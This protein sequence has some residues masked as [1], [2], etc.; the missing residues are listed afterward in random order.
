MTSFLLT[1]DLGTSSERA[2]L[3]DKDLNITGT[4]Q[5]A[6][7]QYYPQ[8]GWVEQ[9]PEEIWQTQLRLTRRLL[10]SKDL[11]AKDI[12][13]IGIT[14][15][16]ETVIVWDRRSGKALYPAIVWQDKR[17]SSRCEALRE[18][19]FSDRVREK[20]GL[21]IDPYFSA[22]KLQWILEKVPG[23]RERAEAGDLLF[24][25]VDSWIVWRLTGG[26]LH[27]TDVSNASRT[28]LFN[29]HDREWDRELLELFAIPEAML[30]EVRSSSEVYT[31]TLPEFFG[32]PIPV[33]GIAG[34]QQ[35]ALFGQ[36]CTEA[37]MAK[38]TYGTGCFMLMNTGS[39]AVRSRHGLLTT[40]AWERD[41]KLSY[42]LEGAVF[43][44]GASIQWL[45][46]NL[47]I[48][49]T[50]ADSAATAAKLRDNGGVYFVPA[51]SGLGAPHWDMNVR[52]TVSGLTQG[53]TAEHLIR[54]ALESIAYQ[55]KD[56]L[57]AM[58]RDS[59][60]RLK[61]LNA[62]GGATANDFL[63]QFQADILHCP[64]HR[65]AI[66]ESTALG[67]AMLAGLACGL[68]TEDWL[69]AFGRHAQC[70][71]PAMPEVRRKTLYAGWQRAVR[72]ARCGS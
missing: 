40:V 63:M 34:D 70:F 51:F 60:V 57:D 55:S 25:T 6:F 46:D 21:I 16:R 56:V 45:R 53:A 20:T 19:G 36:G 11:S 13:G 27:I 35:A 12:A 10:R 4:E 24:G 72:K 47:H 68:W 33:C 59:G 1:F 15:Q 67:A 64:V 8:P 48:I 29:I 30:P 69:R 44:A 17:T 42:A 22:T 2:I 43:T 65:S 9:D 3:F 58:E 62:D 32:A 71:E 66:R 50:A 39:N 49:A 7:P 28:M 18:R 14:N 54:A 61:A 23:A 38:N 37:G 31:E 26:E 52:G 41:G 5:S